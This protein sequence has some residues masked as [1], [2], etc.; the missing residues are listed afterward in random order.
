MG[1]TGGTGAGAGTD[2]A[3]TGGALAAGGVHEDA[4]GLKTNSFALG[5]IVE[6]FAATE[7]NT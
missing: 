1:G 4:F 7:P 6:K 5:F 3:A 2:A